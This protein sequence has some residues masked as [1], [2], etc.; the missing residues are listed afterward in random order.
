MFDD[1]N[2]EQLSA[3]HHDGTPLLIVA[4]AGT[5]KTRTLVSRVV[6]LIDDGV[7]PNRILLLTFTRRAAAEMLS[8]VKAASTNRAAGQVWGG[9]F[10][11]T[12]N[13]LLRSVGQSAGLSPNFTVLDQGDGSGMASYA[14]TYPKMVAAVL[15]ALG[16]STGVDVPAILNR[17]EVA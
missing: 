7:D 4:G 1:L 12:A 14:A 5:G 15:Q 3:V 17:T 9:T 16:E 2:P 10:H 6:R 13:R 11:A 8:R